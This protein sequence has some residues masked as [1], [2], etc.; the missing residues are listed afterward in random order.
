MCFKPTW[1][2][3]LGVGS[4][5]GPN[6]FYSSPEMASIMNFASVTMAWS[7]EKNFSIKYCGRSHYHNWL[8]NLSEISYYVRMPMLKPSFL[9][10]A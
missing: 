7:V 1:D 5:Y 9:P 10:Y 6:G 8:Q 2:S 4:L 3:Y